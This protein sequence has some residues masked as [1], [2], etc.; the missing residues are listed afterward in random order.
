MKKLILVIGMVLVAA[1]PA[2]AD[3][4]W[5]DDFSSAAGWSIVANPSN[6][7]SITS[8][9]NLGSMY[10]GA[11]NSL[12]AFGANTRIPFD[13]ANKSD[14]TLNMTVFDLTLSTSYDV[15][16]DEFDAGSNY[17]ST[18]WQVFPTSFTSTFVGSTNINLG[19]YSFNAG[20]AFVSPKVTIHTGDGTQT[21]RFDSMSMDLQVIPE[22]G[23]LALILG[24]AAML[25]LRRG[26][27][28][29]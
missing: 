29:R 14:Y 21:I 19:A 8:D 27:A 10:V 26:I 15:A 16:L 24:G 17:L 28:R 22:P 2:A 12:A 5:S 1:M 20:S 7:A 3:V 18:V 11:P 6:D 13:P 4:T 23:S 25:L 9:G